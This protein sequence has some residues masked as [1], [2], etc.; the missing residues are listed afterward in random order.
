MDPIRRVITGQAPNG[1]SLVA[2][3]E[4]LTDHSGICVL[5]GVDGTPELPSSGELLAWETMNPPA[6][7]T[8]VMIFDLPPEDTGTSIPPEGN[9]HATD[10]VDVI[11]VLS[12]EVVNESDDGAITLRP[13]EIFIQNGTHHN[14]RNQTKEPATLL[15]FQ[16][17]AS[18]S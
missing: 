11:T 16:L 8:R 5:W 6:G 12:G 2:S 1:R 9:W 10:T 7:G 14:W 17:G 18:R 15:C 3:D 4:V 13:G